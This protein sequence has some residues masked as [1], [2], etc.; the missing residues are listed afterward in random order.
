MMMTFPMAPRISSAAKSLLKWLQVR[1]FLSYLLI[2]S[3]QGEYSADLKVIQRGY[4]AKSPTYQGLDLQGNLYDFRCIPLIT[5]VSNNIGSPQGQIL[6]LTGF[7]FSGNISSV[8]VIAGDY[9]CTVLSSNNYNVVCKVGTTALSQSLYLQGSGIERFLYSGT[10][11]AFTIS[12]G[13]FANLFWAN[14]VSYPL[15]NYQ[16]RNSFDWTPQDGVYS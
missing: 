13:I 10:G 6:T 5:D 2:N 14:N 11:N 8:Q 3:F 1:I 16:I 15:Q 12:N 7:G 4:A 9:P